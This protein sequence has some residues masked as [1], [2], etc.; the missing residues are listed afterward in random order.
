MPEIRK[1]ILGIVPTSR[2]LA[3]RVRLDDQAEATRALVPELADQLGASLGLQPNSTWLIKKLPRRISKQEIIKLLASAAGRWTPSHVSW[4]VE[5]EEPPPRR[6]LRVRGTCATIER[7]TDE[8]TLSPA[9][10]VWAKPIS[11]WEGA[12]S[13]ASAASP[14]RK[15]WADTVDDADSMDFDGGDD[16]DF[17]DPEGG[18]EDQVGADGQ[19]DPLDGQT[20]QPTQPTQQGSQ[21]RRASRVPRQ[22]PFPHVTAM[23]TPYTLGDALAAGE[24][25]RR[26]RA[27]QLTDSS[28][29]D[30]ASPPRYKKR[31]GEAGRKNP[32]SDAATVDTEKEAMRD[33][34]KAKDDQIAAMQTSLNRLQAMMETLMA[35]MASNGTIS[36][37]T[38]AATM[39]E[40]HQAAAPQQLGETNQQQADSTSMWAK[41]TVDDGNAD[42]NL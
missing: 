22:G 4:I 23:S 8:R 2:G 13:R 34:L 28:G 26:P 35:S 15:P 31:F 32:W 6:A 20:M 21:P 7:F 17:M 9:C 24:A 12:A 3:F 42:P 41:P 10:R 18:T 5:A 29:T 33:A 36:T 1:K 30:S 37:Q 11:Q 39:A 14:V 19:C 25:Q 27:F 16:N 40:I 38:A